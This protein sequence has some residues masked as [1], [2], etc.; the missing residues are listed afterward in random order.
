MHLGPSPPTLQIWSPKESSEAGGGS[1]GGGEIAPMDITL[2]SSKH[3]RMQSNE[4]ISLDFELPS[5]WDCEISVFV[6]QAK[7]CLQEGN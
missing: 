6:F 4:N 3:H 2:L 5:R 1:I 7:S